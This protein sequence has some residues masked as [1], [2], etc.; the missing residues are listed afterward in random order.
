MTKA[1][2][3]IHLALQG[4]G[5]H[6]AYTWGVLDK[7]L[8]DGRVD[9]DGICATSAG[10]MNAVVLTYG[11]MQGGNAG[12]REAL[13]NFWHEV[14]E[15][16]HSSFVP[17]EYIKSPDKYPAYKMMAH[18]MYSIFVSVTHIISPYQ[19][20][21]GNHNALRSIIT[22]QV[23]FDKLRKSKTNNLFISTTCVKTGKVKIFKNKELS[24]DVVMASACLP[25]LFQAVKVKNQYYWDGGYMGNPAIFP[26]FN[27]GKTSDI[28]IVHV[29]PIIRKNL[30]HQADEIMD[31]INEITF[32]SSLISEFRAVHFVNKLLEDGWIKD[33][34]KKNLKHILVHS[35]RADNVLNKYDISSKFDTNWH[36]LTHLRDL[37]RQEAKHWLAKNFR[38]LGKK[39]TV[40][41]QNEYLHHGD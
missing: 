31:R 36:F 35:I 6:G 1:Q 15:C 9:F 39:S 20:N 34:F 38:H 5:A 23:D 29:N 27:H 7:L 28:L 8:E 21:P 25:Y 14:S 2:K 16:G 18:M 26:I 11:K 33:K 17:H 30:P 32:N 10:T 12:A 4:G 37:G 40:N 24:A 19:F 22:K 41:I 13:H 3:T